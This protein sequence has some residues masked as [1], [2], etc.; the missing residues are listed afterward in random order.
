LTGWRGFSLP[1]PLRRH[2]NYLYP[3]HRPL[4][5]GCFGAHLSGSDL[6]PP[7]RVARLILFI[8]PFSSSLFNWTIWL[9]NET[10][11]LTA[12]PCFTLLATSPIANVF[13]WNV[14]LRVS[15]EPFR[16][17]TPRRTTNTFYEA[18]APLAL[19]QAPPRS[20]ISSSQ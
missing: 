4:R 16:L 10:F 8:H 6:P 9:T 12:A 18:D 2:P 15:T 19:S 14:D 1:P 11:A 7:P 3:S 20:S 13:S 5:C 17:H